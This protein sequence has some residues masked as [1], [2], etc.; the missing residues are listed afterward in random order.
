M[1]KEIKEKEKGILGDYKVGK[2]TIVVQTIKDGETGKPIRGV[3]CGLNVKN[4]E[5]GFKKEEKINFVFSLDSVPSFKKHIVSMIDQA[6][7]LKA[8]SKTPK[9]P[10]IKTK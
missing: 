4:E 10:K 3:F 5:D 1:T 8:A 7:K 9:T 6:L 2:L